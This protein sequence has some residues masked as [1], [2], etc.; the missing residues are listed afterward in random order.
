MGPGEIE[1]RV[2]MRVT[3]SRTKRP[4]GALLQF[5]IEF[6]HGLCRIGG[7]RRNPA[8]RWGGANGE[9]PLSSDFDSNPFLGDSAWWVV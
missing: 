3:R 2:K 8:V 4:R 9:I 5:G 1:I 7:R 6:G